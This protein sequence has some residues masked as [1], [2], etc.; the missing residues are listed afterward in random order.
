MHRCVHASNAYIHI[1]IH[2]CIHT[3][4]DRETAIKTDYLFMTLYGAY[5]IKE[6]EEEKG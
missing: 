2:T 3:S 6:E 5:I 1:Y 4:I